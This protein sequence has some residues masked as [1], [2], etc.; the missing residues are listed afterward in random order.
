MDVLK[1]FRAR[2]CAGTSGEYYNGGS[3]VTKQPSL[4]T[5]HKRLTFYFN[6]WVRLRDS[7]GD[8]TFTCISCGERKP[9][10][11]MDAG[12]FVPA[13]YYVH[14]YNPSNVWGQCTRCNR[15]MHGNL[16]GYALA[17]VDKLGL[18][19]V[20]FLWRTHNDKAEYTR[21]QLQQ[22]VET[23]SGKVKEMSA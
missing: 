6:L 8:G 12:H 9:V 22:M 2:V 14:R 21:E 7:N 10:E 5:L 11:Q 3:P 18:D 1:L 17:L 16:I 19:Y 23:Y 4:G 13:N 15:F 20:R